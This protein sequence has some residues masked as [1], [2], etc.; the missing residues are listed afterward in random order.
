MVSHLH[1]NARQQPCEVQLRSSSSER[2]SSLERQHLNVG[3]VRVSPAI[4][5]QL[6][7]ATSVQGAFPL[8]I[9]C[10][11]SA[12]VD[13]CHGH[14]CWCPVSWTMQLGGPVTSMQGRLAP[15]SSDSTD[16]SSGP[17]H[18]S[19]CHLHP[20]AL[21]TAVACLLLPFCPRDVGKSQLPTASL[22]CAVQ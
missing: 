4:G 13:W 21:W 6:Q 18:D 14:R 10:I 16:L 7:L 17:S 11:A 22:F 9:G 20:A 1:S 8:V 12:S 15:Q 2:F 19:R 5:L 3:V